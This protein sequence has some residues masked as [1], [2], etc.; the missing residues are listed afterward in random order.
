VF[1]A[2]VPNNYDKVLADLVQ[3]EGFQRG[4]HNAAT[5]VSKRGL[6]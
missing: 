4:Q 1:A 2:A 5:H 3:G 6:Q